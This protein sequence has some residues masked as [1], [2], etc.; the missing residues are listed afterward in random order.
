VR[1]VE[2]VKVAHAINPDI[3]FEVFVH[4]VS[5]LLWLS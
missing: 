1:L 3:T 2:T 4:K 5:T